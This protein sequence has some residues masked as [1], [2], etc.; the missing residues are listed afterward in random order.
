VLST[1]ENELLTRVGPGTPMGELFR[2]FWLPALLPSELPAPDCTPVRLRLLGEDLVA[3]RDSSGRLGLLEERCAHRC[4]SLYY[5]RN[6]E[7]GLRCVYH[8]WKYDVE[9]HCVDLPSE[10]A[11]STYKQRIRLQAYPTREWAGLIWA[12]LGPPERTPELP[13]FEWTLVPD[14]HRHLSKWIQDTNWAQALEGEID[15]SHLS[16]MHSWIDQSAS[17]YPP[18]RGGL[19]WKDKAPRLTVKETDYGFAYGSRRSADDGQ[20]YWR[21]TQFLLPTYSLTSNPQPPEG[22]RCWV[23]I[24]D[25]HTWT[26]AYRYHPERPLTAEDQAKLDSGFLFPPKL[27]PGTFRPVANKENDYLIDRDMQRTK[28]FTGIAGLNNEDRAIQESM[29]PIVDRTREHLVGTDAAII[30]ARRLLLRLAQ[31]LEQGIEPQAPHR[32]ESYRGRAFDAFSSR[33]E[34]DALL[35]EQGTKMLARV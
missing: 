3:F 17:P 32:G 10:P 14:S 12:Y 18:Q 27:V 30:A 2:R 13:R 21:V 19:P 29:G 8:G 20:Y 24:D 4:A 23:P 9:G 28:N 26:F 25:E 5:G 16:F 11:E 15:T 7:D 6:E 33:G 35:E 31:D 1:E 22:G 34:F